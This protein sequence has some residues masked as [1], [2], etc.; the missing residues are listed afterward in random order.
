[1]NQGLELILRLV[2]V[3]LKKEKELA[4]QLSLV[5]RI[6]ISTVR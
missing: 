1:M 5:S 2:M 3:G 4:L 6:F